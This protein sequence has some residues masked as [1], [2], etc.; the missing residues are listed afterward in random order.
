MELG[1][2]PKAVLAKMD[3]PDVLAVIETNHAL[4]DAMDI[5]GT[6][7]FVVDQTMLRGYV[8]LESMRQIVTEQRAG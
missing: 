4:A 5:S 2:D 8:P 1:H 7:T 6:P 3:S